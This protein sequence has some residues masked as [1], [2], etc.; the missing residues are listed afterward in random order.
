MLGAAGVVAAVVGEM[1]A[2]LPAKTTELGQRLSREVPAVIQVLG[3]EPD[4]VGVEGWP[5][6]VVTAVDDR[7]WRP[8][9]DGGWVVS[10][11]VRFTTWVRGDSY[12]ST[13][14]HQRA[15][16]LAVVECLLS[17]VTLTD[18]VTVDDRSL[19]SSMSDIATTDS[20]RTI[21][22]ARLDVRVSV[23]EHLPAPD[24]VAVV[25]ESPDIT[26]LPR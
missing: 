12:E 2:R 9:G 23:E 25:V 4:Q 18:A 5:L 10:Y 14:F 7:D 3:H 15:L 8:L 17:D 20:G 6:L 13:T 22:G 1:S 26:L 16:H 21:A 24:P 19:A 11:G